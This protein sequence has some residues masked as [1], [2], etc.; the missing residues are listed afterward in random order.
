MKGGETM[1][2]AA[3][4]RQEVQRTGPQNV[5]FCG[6]DDPWPYRPRFISKKQRIANLEQHLE[7]LRDEARAVEEH[8]ARIK[9]EK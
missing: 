3:G 2:C 7:V 5:C 8:I 6:C 4:S 9:K 1:C